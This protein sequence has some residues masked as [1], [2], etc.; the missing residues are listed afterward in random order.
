[1]PNAT[2]VSGSIVGVAAD[3]GHHFSKP[4]QR[5][6]VLVEGR[7]IEG[8]AHAGAFVRHRYLARLRPRSA[9]LRQVHL[10]QSEL[11]EMLRAEGYDL[12]VGK[13]GENITT[14]AI[15]LERLPLGT[16]LRL[17]EHAAVELTGLRTPCVLIDRF[18]KGLKGR[19]INSASASPKFRCGV[20]AVVKAG[21]RVVPGDFATAVLPEAPFRPL[22]PL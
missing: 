14:A 16:L 12:S 21:G 4:E 17:G 10:I 5:E 7:G 20:M 1:M 6:I 13:L 18:R 9:N 8:D 3:G 15:E 19:M 22:P 2:P 11:F